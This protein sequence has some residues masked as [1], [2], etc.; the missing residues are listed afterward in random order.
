MSSWGFL[1]APEWAIYFTFPNQ[2][3]PD[4]CQPAEIRRK[5][6]KM[7]PC[8]FSAHLLK[9]Q[10]PVP[11]SC[12]WAVEK[13]IYDSRKNPHCQ[14][15]HSLLT[16]AK[17]SDLKYTVVMC[18]WFFILKI[19]LLMR[20][21]SFYVWEKSINRDCTHK[22][23]NMEIKKHCKCK[24]SDQRNLIYRFSNEK[25]QSQSTA[26]KKNG[27]LCTVCKYFRNVIN[28]QK[29]QLTNRNVAMLA[30]CIDCTG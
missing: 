27:L 10:A 8:Q 23:T 9:P 18:H 22:R 20:R 19:Y 2:L 14:S 24:F 4:S 1:L 16:L 5:R 30:T 17:R 6:K 15:E 25:T 7:K 28:I 29:S 3:S 21:W 13:L 26:K 12:Y 11:F